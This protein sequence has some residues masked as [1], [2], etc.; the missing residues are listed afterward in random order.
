[1]EGDSGNLSSFGNRSFYQLINGTGVLRPQEFVDRELTRNKRK[2]IAGLSLYKKPRCVQGEILKTK[3]LKKV[4]EDFLLKTSAFLGLDEGET[5]ELFTS[6]LSNDY[7]GSKKELQHV[8]RTERLAH[9]LAYKVRDYYYTERLYLLQSVKVIIN[10]WQNNLHPFQREFESFMKSTEVIN[11]SL[12][13]YLLETFEQIS[14]EPYPTWET[15]SILMNDR[16]MYFWVQENLREQCEI[17]EILYIYAKDFDLPEDQVLKHLEL[18]K[19]H[20][21]GRL[22]N[23][24]H[25]IDDS[26]IFLVKRIGYLEVLICI[27][28]MDLESVL[29]CIERGSFSEHFLLKNKETFMRL[30]RIVQSLGTEESHA[31]LLLLW[32]AMHMFGGEGSD[33]SMARKYGNAAIHLRVFHYLYSLLV[34]EPFNEENSMICAVSHFTVYNLLVLILSSFDEHTLGTDQDALAL[35]RVICLVLKQVT[36]SEDFWDKGSDE[37]VGSVFHSAL[38]RFP[39]DYSSFVQ[40]SAALAG[41]TPTSAERVF[42]MWKQLQRYTEYLDCNHSSDLTSTKEINEWKLVVN[43]QPYPN[44]DF[45]L[46]AGTKGKILTMGTKHDASPIIQWYVTF[47]GWDLLLCEVEMLLDQIPQGSGLVSPTQIQ[48]VTEAVE[49]VHAVLENHPQ[50]Q[51]ELQPIIHCIYMLIQ[52]FVRLSHP[53]V[54]L[55]VQCIECVT[56]LAKQNPVK[57]WHNMKQTGLLPYLT[58]NIDNISEILSGQGLMAGCYGNML[59]GVECIEGLYPITMAILEF[60]SNVIQPFFKDSMENELMASILYIL[61]EVFPVFQKWRFY[62]LKTRELIGRKC[63]EIF[64][65]TLENVITRS[66]PEESAP[67]RP[68]VQEVVVYSL[69]FTEAGQTLL[70]IIAT[71]TDNVDLALVQQGSMADG[72]LGAEMIRLILTSFS[73][74]NQLLLLKS[75]DLPLSPVESALSSQPVVRQNQHIVAT[76]AQYIYHK[77]DPRLPKLACLLL[78]RLALVTKMSILSCFG[79]AAE[80]VRDMYLNRL[81]GA[82]EDLKLKVAILEFLSV[83]VDAQPGLIEMFLNVQLTESTSSEAA[84][85]DL[86]IGKISCLQTVLNLMEADKQMTYKCPSDLLC[87]CMEFINSLWSGHRETAMSVLRTCDKFWMSVCAPLSRNLPDPQDDPDKGLYTY[88]VKTVSHVLE[89]LAEEIFCVASGKLDEKLKKCLTEINA[90]NRLKYWTGQIR[91]CLIEESKQTSHREENLSDH[92]TLRLLIAWKNFLITQSRVQVEQLKLDNQLKEII[93]IDLIESLR[94]LINGS[95]TALNNKLAKITS[96]LV[97]RLV[98]SW[99]SALSVLRRTV[100]DVQ[101]AV[102]E[103]LSNNASVIPSLQIGM[104]GSLVAMLQHVKVNQA[105]KLDSDTLLEVLKTTCEVIHQSIFQLPAIKDLTPGSSG[106]VW[107]KMQVVCCCL[108][109]EV[110]LQLPAESSWLPVLQEHLILS[111]LLSSVEY[112]IKAK[113][114]LS[115]VHTVM[116]L[117]LTVAKHE[118]G[119][120]SLATSGL[121]QHLCL[122]VINLYE[123]LEPSAMKQ[124]MK[125]S[126]KQKES[127]VTYSWHGIYCLTLDLYATSLLVLRFSF[128]EDT[129]HFL[130]AHQDRMLQCF[131]LSKVLLQENVLFEAEKTCDFICHLSGYLP[132][133]RVSSPDSVY[134][135][136]A[137]VLYL[138]QTFIA[139]LSSTRYLQYLLENRAPENHMTRHRLQHQAS[140]E[141][142]FPTKH[143]LIIKKRMLQILGRAFSML[144]Y[145]TPE[146]CEV[147]YER[148]MDYAEH[149]P[150]LAIAFTA[151]SVDQE[152]VPSFGMFTSCVRDVCVRLLTKQEGKPGHSPQSSSETSVLAIIPKSLIMYVMENALY[153]VMSQAMR[154]LRDPSLLQADKQLLKRELGTEMNFFLMEFQRYLKRGAPTSPSPSSTH[155]QPSPKIAGTPSVLGRSISQTALMSTPELE[156]VKFVQ[157]FVTAVL[158]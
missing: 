6:F 79:G 19:R 90:S 76:V 106:E 151:P 116:L 128:L 9:A 13:K 149:Q 71:G 129:F 17:L 60:I 123:D 81:Q 31:P 124:T 67:K 95:S 34:S 14:Q 54:S 118:K 35:H 96:A 126:P 97:F 103:A 11:G 55:I 5:Y 72:G 111:S 15:N 104:V 134:Q 7:R 99:T 143:V 135:L 58:E 107:L 85:R 89:I 142:E 52:R 22:Q 132:Q 121:T 25:L 41:S 138:S 141:E 150:F 26:L 73:V 1:M 24:K 91:D 156:F 80:S 51:R 27:E 93:I 148:N 74:L 36:V 98:S 70:G 157:E 8:F 109:E 137:S 155:R 29:A 145:F 56:C 30:D 63:V 16:Q 10:S 4:T 23:Y 130:G 45:M 152:C 28:M 88:Q 12:Q 47:S 64:H 2:I 77:H 112:F 59:F 125:K 48:K 133:W 139:Y 69:L 62:K 65:K 94:A 136:Q 114:G 102:L 144:R 86:S 75:P 21:F 66:K 119:A 84:R 37:G 153:L 53:P 113:Q 3:K 20:G 38:L 108:L 146:L 110:I 115:F 117:F 32:S 78:K 82:T 122:S 33:F 101:T 57:V 131:E 105:N 140:T 44:K 43:K 49:L 100:R 147:L 92:H 39:L 61:R 83:C 154:L 127:S 158:K 68:R 120:E 46:T 42:H 50:S 87:A 40:F 18:F